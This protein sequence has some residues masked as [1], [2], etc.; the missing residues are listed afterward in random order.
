M[1]KL[2][3]IGML[4]LTLAAII[5]FPSHSSSTP[6]FN[7]RLMMDL[8]MKLPEEIRVKVKEQ[9]N[10]SPGTFLIDGK[11]ICENSKIIFSLNEYNELVHIGL[12]VKNELPEKKHYLTV[13]NYIERLLLTCCLLNNHEAILFHLQLEKVEI[14]INGEP[15]A[16]F[17]ANNSFCDAIELAK[18]AL[19][20]IERSLN[21][22]H[23]IYSPDLFNHVIITFPADIFTITGMDKY[24]IENM[25]VRDMG[26]L[27]EGQTVHVDNSSA[28]LYRFSNRV[29][30]EEGFAYFGIAGISSNQF[31]YRNRASS[32]VFD[33]GNF[34]ESASNLF[35]NLI[36]SRISLQINHKLYGNR[37]ENYTVNVNDFLSYF[38]DD[39]TIF[40][41]WQNRNIENLIASVFIYNNVFNYSHMLT[42]SFKREDI[43]NEEGIIEAT[44]Y[45]FTPHGNLRTNL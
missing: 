5:I 44:F 33:R 28:P 34:Y 36:P 12:H 17:L 23:A 14:T 43:F 19:V 24:E 38:G 15:L 3:F 1:G 6:A 7:S 2:Q 41:G 9:H 4:L 10:T 42:M 29:S 35:L 26:S 16:D 18:N 13:I 25:F 11:R 22:F 45:S 27:P 20:S 32:P 40:F 37:T 31:F 30:M 8:Y 39:Y 21:G